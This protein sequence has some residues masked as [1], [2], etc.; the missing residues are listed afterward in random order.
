MPNTKHRYS[1]TILPTAPMKCSRRQ[2]DRTKPADYPTPMTIFEVTEVCPGQVKDRT[3]DTCHLVVRR[4]GHE[5]CKTRTFFEWRCSLCGA[6]H[7]TKGTEV[8]GLK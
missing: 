1:T 5:S 6:H 2:D 3:L 8:I 7:T 4:E